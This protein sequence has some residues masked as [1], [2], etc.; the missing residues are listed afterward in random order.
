M[1]RRDFVYKGYLFSKEVLDKTSYDELEYLIDTIKEDIKSNS[2]LILPYVDRLR[3]GKGDLTDV[4]EHIVKKLKYKDAL[5]HF[6]STLKE[7]FLERKID[8]N[9]AFIEVCRENMEEDT[10]KEFLTLAEKKINS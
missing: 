1:E 6:L 2:D 8:I 4:P 3:S 7:A 10:F 9:R 5:N